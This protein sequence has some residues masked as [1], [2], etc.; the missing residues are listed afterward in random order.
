MCGIAGYVGTRPAV[1]VVVDQL[2]RLEYRGYDSA[3]VASVSPADGDA[4][5]RIEK[6]AG[7]LAALE[8]LLDGRMPDARVAVAHTRWATHGKPTTPNAHPHPDCSGKIV[9]CHNGIIE[10]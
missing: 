9:V 3:G 1:P 4:A 7:K 5:I 6:T 10:N 8:A 2:R